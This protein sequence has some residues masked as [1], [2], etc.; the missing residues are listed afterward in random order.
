LVHTPALAIGLMDRDEHS[1]ESCKL[2]H[3]IIL[4][5][6]QP[7]TSH[8]SIFFSQRSNISLNPILPFKGDLARDKKFCALCRMYRLVNMCFDKASYGSHAIEPSPINR[9]LSS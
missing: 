9:A 1:P 7:K 3:I 5:P 4:I 2:L 6:L 8:F